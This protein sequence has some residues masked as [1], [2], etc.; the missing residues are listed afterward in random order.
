MRIT[1]KHFSEG[2]FTCDGV[3][4]YDLMSDE[5]LLKLE[6]ARVIAGIPFTINSSWRSKAANER[7]GGKSNSAH[8]RGNAVDIACANSSDRHAILNACIVVGITR[9]GIANTFIHIDVDKDL[10]NNVIWTY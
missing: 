9:I 2:E 10:P 5:L 6:T 8:L 3:E 1:I 7:V 4:C